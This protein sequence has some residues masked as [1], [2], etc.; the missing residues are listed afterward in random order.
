[1]LGDD[2]RLRRQGGLGVLLNASLLAPDL[3][4]SGDIDA[5]SLVNSRPEKPRVSPVAVASAHA[6]LAEA[7]RQRA[8]RDKQR[9][10]RKKKKKSCSMPLPAALSLV[11]SKSGAPRRARC[12]AYARVTSSP[13]PPQRRTNRRNSQMNCA[14][15]N[16]SREMRPRRGQTQSFEDLV[17]R[18]DGSQ[19][20][21]SRA[22]APL[23]SRAAELAVDEPRHA[24]FDGR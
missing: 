14:Q 7:K 6:V 16:Q 18:H 5:A 13:A 9:K 24:P 17:A 19:A 23:Q 3:L 4:P 22:R 1:M 12:N 2:C 21:Q 11:T 8:V 15:R 10:N 20:A